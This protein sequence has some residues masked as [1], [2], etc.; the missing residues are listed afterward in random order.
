LFANQAPVYPEPPAG[1]EGMEDVRTFY[2]QIYNQINSAFY[3][4]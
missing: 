2:A 4:E 3:V 1:G